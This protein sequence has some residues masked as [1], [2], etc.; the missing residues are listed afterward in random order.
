MTATPPDQAFELPDWMQPYYRAIDWGLL[1]MLAL[2]LFAALP[3]LAR[4]GLP[5]ETDAELH[6]FRTTELSYCIREGTVYPR[7]APNFWYGYGYPFFNYYASLTYYLAAGFDL[8]TGAGPVEGVRFVFVLGQVAAGL[9][10]YAFV[11]RRWNAR[12]GILAG[13][14][15]VYSPYLVLIDP[16]MRGDMAEAFAL[17]MLPA[18]LWAFD[19]LLREGRGRHVAAAALL[20]A[21]LI[22]THNLMA[23]IFFALLVGW[24][25]WLRLYIPDYHWCRAW[26]ALALALGLASF[27]WLPVLLESGEVQLNRLTGPGHFDYRTHFLTPGELLAPSPP[28]DLTAANPA[29]AFNL[30]LAA[31]VLALVGCAALAAQGRRGAPPQETRAA[32]L[33]E[34][35]R[36][37][38]SGAT[39]KGAASPGGVRDA[40]YFAVA[41]LALVFLMLPAADLVWRAVPIMPLL[42]F[43]WRLLGPASFCLAVL[44]G[45]ATRWIGHLPEVIRPVGLTVLVAVPLF[46]SIST[47][48]PPEWGPDFGE[49]STQAYLDFELS[50]VALGTTAGG[51][52]LP[53]EVIV[54]PSPQ[55]TLIES[56]SRAGPIDKVNR[57]TLPPETIV[58]VV[59]HGPVEDR[60]LVRSLEPFLLRLYTFAFAGWQVEI[61]GRPVELEV[62]EPEGFIV[63]DVP[64]GSHD[65]CAF[66][67]STPVRDFAGAL[68]LISLI[69]LSVLVITLERQARWPPSRANPLGW[70]FAT[71]ILVVGV[72][73]AGFRALS[74]ARPGTFYVRSVPGEPLLAEH[75]HHRP[76]E[77]GI[78]L[79]AYDLPRQT[80]H[81]GE[82]LSV[83]LYWRAVRP[84]EENYQVF[85]HLIPLGESAPRAQSDKLNP[86]DYPTT[87]WSPDRYIRDAHEI[88]LPAD[89]PPGQYILAVGLYNLNTSKRVLTAGPTPDDKAVLP[90]FI[91][92]A[93]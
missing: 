7:W 32:T 40:A 74:D 79:L 76:F 17:G 57:T 15:Y 78:E 16:H 81:P 44:A 88:A 35:Q 28:L 85:V 20:L 27:F 19:R 69:V 84:L 18:V 10:T 92:V 66:L 22:F 2:S 51:E 39:D 6:V 89:L 41:G 56:Y 53:D 50:G 46:G 61:D 26:A 30:G 3:F 87:R 68:T 52:F 25:A 42:Q 4:P 12:A 55:S 8:L 38:A 65:V 58:D 82:I 67:G 70:Q 77:T 31:W 83:T 75:P 63:V 91:E 37:F 60:F 29:Y 93:P 59:Y 71:A 49:T 14:V 48:Y 62:G 72:L 54:P 43:P 33:E 64:A 5:R 45:A 86:G 73:F 80:L 1:L 23:L 9:G 36:V 13:V 11:R 34:W 47:L 90:A 21:A 24:L